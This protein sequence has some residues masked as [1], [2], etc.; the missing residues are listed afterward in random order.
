MERKN[1]SSGTNWEAVAGYSRA[2]RLGNVVEVAGTTSV[3]HNG[4]LFGGNS[5]Y[6]QAMYIFTKIER[7][8]LEAGARLEDVVR[9]RMYVTDIKRWEEVARAHGEVFGEIRP[10]STLVEVSALVSPELLVEIEV[11]AIIS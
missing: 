11:T 2:V 8:L 1:F 10:A 4:Q 3:D 9:T 5:P 7:A 6:M